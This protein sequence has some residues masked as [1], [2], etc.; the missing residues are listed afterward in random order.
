MCVLLGSHCT[1]GG[2][3]G[4]SAAPAAVEQLAPET[5]GVAAGLGAARGVVLRG[6]GGVV[7]AVAARK[8]LVAVAD[9]EELKGGIGERLAPGTPGAGDGGAIESLLAHRR[10]PR[11]TR[12]RDP[13]VATLA[14]SPGVHGR[15]SYTGDTVTPH[16]RTRSQEASP[17]ES[18]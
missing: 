8:V 16:V 11:G 18:D 7:E 17:M 9:V 2:P 12:R 3:G 10:G 1:T 13:S 14:P 15:K 5:V 4:R 6:D